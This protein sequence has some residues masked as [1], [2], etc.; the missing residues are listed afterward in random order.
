VLLILI[1]ANSYIWGQRLFIENVASQAM[2][3]ASVA[4]SGADNA[5]FYNPAS[6]GDVTERKLNICD[7]TARVNS[8]SYSYV[9]FYRKNR[10]NIHKIETLD[11]E[12]QEDLYQKSRDVGERAGQAHFTFASALP[13]TY[14]QHDFGIGI[15]SLGNVVGEIAPGALSLPLVDARIQ[16]DVLVII[17]KSIRLENFASEKISVG[18]SAKYLARGIYQKRKALP[19]FTK[20][21]DF[22]KYMGESYGLDIGGLYRL[23][24]RVSLGIGLYDIFASNFNWKITRNTLISQ[25]PESNIDPSMRI[26]CAIQPFKSSYNMINDL[27]FAIDYDQPFD[28]DISFFKKIYAGAQTQFRRIVRLRAGF[29][30]GYPSWGIGIRYK[31]IKIDYTFYSNELGKYPGQISNY[32]HAMRLQ[33]GIILGK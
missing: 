6:L 24:K 25:V 8:A 12:V 19:G 20:D 2:G 22:D 33:C 3:G 29:Y 31:F 23:S 13:V 14:T 15:Y 18:V 30:Q 32:Q 28:E 27:M 4:V 9:S 7:L 16:T 5:F 10:S 11:D 26:G 17:S 21:E 1:C